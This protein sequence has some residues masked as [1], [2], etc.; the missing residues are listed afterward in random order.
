M[1][2]GELECGTFVVNSFRVTDDGNKQRYIYIRFYTILEFNLLLMQRHWRTQ[3]FPRRRNRLSQPTLTDIANFSHATYE[4][5]CTVS[6]IELFNVIKFRKMLS[7]IYILPGE[8]LVIRNIPREVM[9]FFSL[10]F[11][12]LK[13]VL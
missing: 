12:L 9:H 5:N 4:K 10:F 6:P 8:F 13:R 3:V 1:C 2:P 11:F 7:N